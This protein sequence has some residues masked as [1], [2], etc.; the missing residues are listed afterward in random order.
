MRR[1]WRSNFMHK[2]KLNFSQNLRMK[3]FWNFFYWRVTKLDWKFTLTQDQLNHALKN[4]TQ[5]DIGKCRTSF[6]PLVFYS[7]EKHRLLCSKGSCFCYVKVV[8]DRI[9]THC[10]NKA[11]AAASITFIE[12]PGQDYDCIN[13]PMFS[14][15][16]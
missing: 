14:S 11:N 4:W 16:W 1:F 5:K 13:M 6:Y 12:I 3:I 2:V 7:K 9:I 15:L 8:C 10:L